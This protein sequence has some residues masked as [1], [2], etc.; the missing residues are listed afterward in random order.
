MTPK[1]LDKILAD[2]DDKFNHD[3][4]HGIA[5]VFR[6]SDN[7]STTQR[8][9]QDELR[10]FLRQSLASF[11][12]Y[13]AKEVKRT[14]DQSERLKDVEIYHSALTNLAEQ[15]YAKSEY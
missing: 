2:F 7:G 9:A 15:T 12:L 1:S 6:S 14:I 3:D 4:P 11:L 5:I 13:A 10:E 8:P